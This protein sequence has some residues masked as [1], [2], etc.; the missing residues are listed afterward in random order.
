[1]PA[2]DAFTT[3]QAD[4]IRH[5]LANARHDTGLYFSVYV[6]SA[7]GDVRD[8]A[9]RLHSALGDDADL[10]VLILVEPEARRVEI[11]TGDLAR[12]RLDDRSCALASLTMA[13][14]FA[15][16]DLAGGLVSG[17]LMMTQAA[18]RPPVLHEHEAD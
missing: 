13:A 8:Y 14:S 7:A 17:V 2:G 18:S 16:G 9:L 4:Q 15:G 5:A 3:R 10:G 12:R 1:M 11:V 6:G